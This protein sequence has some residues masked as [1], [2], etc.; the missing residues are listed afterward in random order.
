MSLGQTIV[1]LEGA[2]HHETERA[3]LF[4]LD[5]D[6]DN[7]VWLAKSQIEIEIEGEVCHVGCPVWLAREKGLV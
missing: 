1:D 6:K 3:I 4:S 7:A 2:L 5:G